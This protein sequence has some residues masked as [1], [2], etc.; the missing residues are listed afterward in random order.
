MDQI[1]AVFGLIDQ[2]ELSGE[3]V[4]VAREEL[5]EMAVRMEYWDILLEQKE[6]ASVGIWDKVISDVRAEVIEADEIKWGGDEAL[7]FMAVT[8][9]NTLVL[10]KLGIREEVFEEIARTNEASLKELQRRLGVE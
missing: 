6:K 8:D 1:G 4:N 2:Y 7:K 9:E 3:P 5:M 10:A